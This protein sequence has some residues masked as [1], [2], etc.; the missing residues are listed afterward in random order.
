MVRAVARKPAELGMP[1]P[2]ARKRSYRV[3]ILGPSTAHCEKC[4]ADCSDMIDTWT[5]LGLCEGC[6]Q[7]KVRQEKVSGR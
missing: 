1:A 6:Y 5:V 3:A 7:R 4:L 2:E